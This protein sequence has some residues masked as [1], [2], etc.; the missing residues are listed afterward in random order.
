[1]KTKKDKEIEALREE[2]RDLR[3]KLA[4]EKKLTSEAT[5]AVSQIMSASDAVIA[6]IID[7]VN[8]DGRIVVPADKVKVDV[9]GRKCKAEKKDGNYIY[10]V[11]YEEGEQK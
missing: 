1:M 9:P 4:N 5:K 11:V 8:D 6:A 7:I 2:I 3:L 10:S